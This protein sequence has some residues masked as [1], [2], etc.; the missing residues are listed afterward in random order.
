MTFITVFRDPVVSIATDQLV[1]DTD[2]VNVVSDAMNMAANVVQQL[3]GTEKQLEITKQLAFNEAYEAGKAAGIEAGKHEIAIK[4]TELTANAHQQRLTLQGSVARLAVQVVRKIAG[5]IGAS[6][7]V[8]NL[9]HTAAS[10]LVP[11]TSLKL[12][13]HPDVVETVSSRLNSVDSPLQGKSLHIEIRTDE[14][15][16]IFDCTL[17]TDYGHTVA[18][19]NDQLGRLESVIKDELSL[20]PNTLKGGQ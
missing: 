10:E 11:G 2:E 4:L 7:M 6:E 8:S 16:D 3:E 5:E 17:S 1:L 18:G 15:L 9:A 20:A 12:W 13:V 14:S 19:L